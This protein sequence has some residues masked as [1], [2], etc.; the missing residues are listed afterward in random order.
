MGFHIHRSSIGEYALM[1]GIAVAKMRAKMFMPIGYFETVKPLSGSVKECHVDML[2]MKINK[3]QTMIRCM[4]NKVITWNNWAF[5]TF[6]FLHKDIY[7]RG[8]INKRYAHVA[9]VLGIADV[10]T[11]LTIIV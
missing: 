6:Q 7:G 9:N 4:L 3:L 10:S 8:D 2:D 5:C 11:H 1:G